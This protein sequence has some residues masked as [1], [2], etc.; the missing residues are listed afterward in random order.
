MR[1]AQR[2]LKTALVG[3]AGATLAFT[4]LHLTTG[5]AMV[6]VAEAGKGHKH[7]D[8]KGHKH[9]DHKGHKGHKHGHQHAHRNHGLPCQVCGMQMKPLD[10][11]GVLKRQGKRLRFCS[12]AHLRAYKK[13]PSK[14]KTPPALVRDPVCGMRFAK[15][16]AHSHVA[17]GGKKV[18]FCN[19]GCKKRFL[20][21]P[22]K[23]AGRS[24][25]RSRAA[26]RRMRR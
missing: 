16:A 25:S 1:R 5:L 18:Y 7:G 21:T 11:V 17:H 6:P 12:L 20:A 4:T 15:A 22:K 2:A 9:G 19:A 10:V 13:C 23:W 14:Y 26:H 8:H 24:H 3:L